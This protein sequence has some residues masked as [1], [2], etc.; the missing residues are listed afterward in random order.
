[1]C[2]KKQQLFC[3]LEKINRKCETI[4]SITPKITKKFELTTFY[5]LQDDSFIKLPERQNFLD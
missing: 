4:L 5:R 1:M 2:K 3:P